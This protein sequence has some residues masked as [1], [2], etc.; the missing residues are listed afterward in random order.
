MKRI[1]GET[2]ASP[3]LLRNC[4]EGLPPSQV[5]RP[6]G[7]YHNLAERRWKPMYVRSKPVFLPPCPVRQGVLFGKRVEARI[8][9]WLL[10]FRL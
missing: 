4:K 10:L 6:N 7:V 8:L 3:V 5:A 9:P 2:G 1:K